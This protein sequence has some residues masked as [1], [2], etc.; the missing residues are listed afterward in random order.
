L[1]IV[2]LLRNQTPTSFDSPILAE[3]SGQ[4]KPPRCGPPWHAAKLVLNAL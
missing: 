3:V 2:A 1:L 4:F